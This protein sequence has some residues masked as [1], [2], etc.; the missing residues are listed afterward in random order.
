VSEADLA[1]MS[2]SQLG[3]L[4]S[5]TTE[6]D[7]ERGILALKHPIKIPPGLL[8]QVSLQLKATRP[9]TVNRNAVKLL[10]VP[11][12]FQML[13]ECQGGAIAH[14]CVAVLYLLERKSC[15]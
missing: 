9:F 15:F 8:T 14:L 3:Q 11:R 6:V 4:A 10:A 7:R 2:E 13:R 12:G 1:A 5:V